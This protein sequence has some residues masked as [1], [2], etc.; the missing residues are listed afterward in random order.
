MD[1]NLT[2][3]AENFQQSTQQFMFENKD[4]PKELRLFLALFCRSAK[5]DT[6]FVLYCLELLGVSIIL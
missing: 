4:V 5:I 3:F 2:G 6:L 1:I